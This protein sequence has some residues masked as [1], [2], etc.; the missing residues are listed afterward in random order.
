[1]A[2]VDLNHS[3]HFGSVFGLIFTDTMKKLT[4]QIA[5]K[6]SLSNQQLYAIK[7]IPP[8][9]SILS[10]QIKGNTLSQSPSSIHAQKPGSEDNLLLYNVGLVIELW[11]LLT[12]GQGFLFLHLTTSITA[13]ILRNHTKQLCQGN[14]LHHLHRNIK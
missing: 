1:M 10:N 9:K 4:N 2:S 3:N 11:I 13:K 7:Q 12:L 6:I 5:G 14:L 8:I